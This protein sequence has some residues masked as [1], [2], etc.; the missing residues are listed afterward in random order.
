[1]PFY[2]RNPTVPHFFNKLLQSKDASLRL[3]TTSLLLRN[4]K[5]VADSIIRTL[6]ASDLYRSRLLKSLESIHRG[7]LFPRSFRNQPDIAR[8]LLVSNRGD[9]E[10][11][12]IQWVDKKMIQFKGKKGTIYFFKYKM[13]KDDEWQIGLSGLQ[14]VN[15][16]EVNTDGEFVQLTGKKIRPN[17]PVH[18]QFDQQLKKLIFSKH[19]SAAAFYQDNEYYDGKN[20]DD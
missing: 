10:M 1:M 15:T 16:K 4:N 8:S 18:D 2:D 20:D 14:P 11:A 6:A 17:L 19:K 9:N 12:A 5:P 3:S 13:N 7:S